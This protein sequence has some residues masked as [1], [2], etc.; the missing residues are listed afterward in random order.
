MQLASSEGKRVGLWNNINTKI[1]L[2]LNT[3]QPCQGPEERR[4]THETF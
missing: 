4:E 3:Y 1:A 2:A